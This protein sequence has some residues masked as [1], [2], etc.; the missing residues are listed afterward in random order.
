[1][2]LAIIV[3]VF[4]RRNITVRFLE[5]LKQ[6]TFKEFITIVVDDGSK[7]G[8][9]SVVKEKFSDVH[10]IKGSGSW[11][12]TK[13][14]N[15]GISYAITLGVRAVLLMNDDTY[16]E[17]DYL[18]N[19]VLASNANP[20]S[21]VGSLSLTYEKPERIFFSGVKKIKLFSSKGS[22]YHSA[23][24]LYKGGLTGNKPTVALPGR[25]LL[26]PISIINRY[27]FFE[28]DKLPQYG[29]DEAYITKLYRLNRKPSYISWDSRI[30]TYTSMTGKGASFSNETL[31]EFLLS[32]F[33]PKSRQYIPDKWYMS[34]IRF[35]RIK[36]IMGF[37]FSIL[38]SLYGFLKKNN[39]K[40][41]SEY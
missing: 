33:T 14:V 26:I 39:F 10:I 23:F 17:P 41:S 16:F 27:G 4:N 2:R 7:D 12:W 24:E 22:K 32:F 19:L 28:E 5:L 29:A 1:M 38:R 31:A 20:E 35:G 9:S 30:Y 18:S 37:W 13:S 8:T 15:K 34:Q 36:G 3:P 25:G 40:S 6:Q 21:I 11:W